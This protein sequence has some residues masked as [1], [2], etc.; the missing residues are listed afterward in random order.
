MWTQCCRWWCRLGSTGEAGRL[1]QGAG[2]LMGAQLARNGAI[3]GMGLAG[4]QCRRAASTHG[5]SPPPQGRASLHGLA[6]GAA[7]AGL[8]GEGVGPHH[9][10]RGLGECKGHVAAVAGRA[11]APGDAASVSG[12]GVPKQPELVPYLIDCCALV[13]RHRLVTHLQDARLRRGWYGGGSCRHQREHQPCCGGTPAGRAPTRRCL[14]HPIVVP[15][16]R[17]ELQAARKLC[18]AH[19]PNGHVSSRPRSAGSPT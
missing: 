4:F 11:H 15:W 10:S 13:E 17:R 9:V 7:G 2:H 19:R 18:G 16:D 5:M 8:Q 1:Q 12:G 6:C 14:P 3:K